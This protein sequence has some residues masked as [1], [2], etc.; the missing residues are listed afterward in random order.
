MGASLRIKKGPGDG[1]ELRQK[2]KRWDNKNEY[3]QNSDGTRSTHR[4]AWATEDNGAIAFPTVYPKD[5][6]GT[7]SHDPKDWIELKGKEAI[8][9]ARAR[10][11]IYHFKKSENAQKWADG[12]Y[13]KN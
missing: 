6:A 13:K 4:M 2:A 10:G 1:D 9:T 5:R 7:Q 12:E 8:D 3:R 11:E